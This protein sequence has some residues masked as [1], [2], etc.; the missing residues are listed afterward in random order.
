MNTIL[1]L[2]RFREWRQ[3]NAVERVIQGFLPTFLDNE[4]QKIHLVMDD[5]LCPRTDGKT[6]WISLLE[7]FLAD[8]YS[9]EDWCIALRAITAHEAQHINSSNFSDIKK[10]MDWYG[11]YME[12]QFS[13]AARTGQSIAKQALNIIEDGRIEAIAVKRRPGMLVPFMFLNSVIRNGCAVDPAADAS[14]HEENEWRAFWNNVLSYAKTGLYSPGMETYAGTEM[15]RQFLSVQPLI[16]KGISAR[17]SEDCRKITE[18]M[19]T[20]LAPYLAKRIHDSPELENSLLNEQENEYTSNSESQYGDGSSSSP[21]RP[22]ASRSSAGQ[23]GN[24]NGS[25]NDVGNAETPKDGEEPP[26]CPHSGFANANDANLPLDKE[27]LDAIRDLA[28]RELHNAKEEQ[29]K[30]T[31]SRTGSVLDKESLNRIKQQYGKARL[32]IQETMPAIPTSKDLPDTLKLQAKELRRE[33][34]RVVE[35]RR[36]KRKNLRCGVLDQNALWRTGLQDTDIFCRQTRPAFGSVAF[37]ILMDNSGSMNGRISEISGS[38]LD[39]NEAARTAAAVIE[40]AV[41]GIIPC[42]IALFHY[43]DTV[44]HIVIRDFDNASKWN[45]SWN[46]LGEIRPSGRNMDSVNIRI[47]GE[48]LAKRRERKKVLLLLSD[49]LPSAY[50]SAADAMA[51]V[52]DAVTDV[53]KKGTAVIPLMF[54]Q[55]DFF[56][57]YF[58]KYKAMYEKNIIACQPQDVIFELIRI[59]RQVICG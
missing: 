28:S 15:E 39:K 10:I 24:S 16:D 4:T 44:E 59:F 49:G 50:G 51:E 18:E 30:E 47:A 46:S 23:V 35:F 21:L 12:S 31:D 42:K 20:V 13:I 55:N 3:N 5:G 54:G 25:K 19:L 37:Y 14:K 52:R 17:T 1:S 53:R 27:K 57:N 32:D 33:I 36:K 58:D 34:T 48:E 56:V 41:Q 6:I 45:R 2:T 22:G 26:G 9:G 43:I 8:R 7:D 38:T 11:E 40:E 29:K